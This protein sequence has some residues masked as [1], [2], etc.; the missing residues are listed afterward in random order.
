MCRWIAY[1]GEPMFMEDFVTVP[2]Q[3]LVVQSRTSK[4]ARNAVNGDGFG[5]GW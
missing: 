2:R 1:V 4:E 3:S 5:L